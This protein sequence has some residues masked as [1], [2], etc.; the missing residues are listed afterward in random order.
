MM[1]TR[2]NKV[3]FVATTLANALILIAEHVEKHHDERLYDVSIYQMQTID[4]CQV[5]IRFMK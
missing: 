4:A 5:E 1:K 2:Y 3:E